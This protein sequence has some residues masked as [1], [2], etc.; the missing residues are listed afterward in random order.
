MLYPNITY[1]STT[2][3]DPSDSKTNVTEVSTLGDF[4]LN[5]TSV[6]LLGPMQINSSFAMVSLTLPIINNTSHIDVLG[7]MT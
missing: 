3:T 1:K 4:F 2:N 7:F 5:R 6:L